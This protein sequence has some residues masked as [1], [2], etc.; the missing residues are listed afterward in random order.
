[1]TL[2]EYS[3]DIIH[4]RDLT[5]AISGNDHLLELNICD[6]T[7]EGGEADAF[8]L[9]RAVRGHPELM[10]FKLINVKCADASCDLDQ[11]LSMI[12]VT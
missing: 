12:L 2:L 11:M 10:E 5:K 1:M 3:N 9:S 4:F 8:E 6:V 7:L